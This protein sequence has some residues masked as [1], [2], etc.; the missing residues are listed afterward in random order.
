MKIVYSKNKWYLDQA[1]QQTNIKPTI[2][3]KTE[4][5]RLKKEQILI[6]FK[7]RAFDVPGVIITSRQCEWDTKK[8][9]PRYQQ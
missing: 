4:N 5:F 1:A 6:K 7:P 2:L 8:L 9:K 3:I